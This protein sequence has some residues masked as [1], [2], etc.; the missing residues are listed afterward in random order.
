MLDGIGELVDI[1]TW[2]IARERPTWTAYSILMSDY[3]Q[4]V[5]PHQMGAVTL[6]RLQLCPKL[7][8]KIRPHV[9]SWQRR[10]LRC[11]TEG[12]L[13]FA[14][15]IPNDMSD[16][17]NA[18]FQAVHR[19][20]EDVDFARQRILQ[21][22][23]E[24][25]DEIR[26]IQKSRSRTRRS[27]PTR[28][29]HHLKG[30]KRNRRKAN[31]RR[32]P[33]VV[34]AGPLL[35]HD[36]RRLKALHNDTYLSRPVRD[37]IT[38]ILM[39]TLAT[40]AIG[41]L[42][43][44][45][46]TLLN[47]VKYS[48][49]DTLRK[50]VNLNSKNIEELY[51]DTEQIAQNLL[52]AYR[53][54]DQ[55]QDE[56]Q[57]ITFV[58]DAK[59]SLLQT[60][61]VFNHLENSL[62]DSTLQ[63]LVS[64]SF[65]HYGMIM[66]N[67]LTET[68]LASVAQALSQKFN[69]A[70]SS[71]IRDLTLDVVQHP[72]RKSFML[73]FQIPTREDFSK[74]KIYKVTAVP[75]LMQDPKEENGTMTIPVLESNFIGYAKEG[76]RI[77][78]LTPLEANNCLHTRQCMLATPLR[79]ADKPTTCQEMAFLGLDQHHCTW[80]TLAQEGSWFHTA[81]NVTFYSMKKPDTAEIVCPQHFGKEA[82]SYSKKTLT[83][84]GWM[85]VAWR[86]HIQMGD[87]QLITNSDADPIHSRLHLQA[88]KI[89]YPVYETYPH[90][91]EEERVFYNFTKLSNQQYT[92]D[93]ALL[94]NNVERRERAKYNHIDEFE[95]AGSA[96]FRTIAIVFGSLT[97]VVV[98]I[99]TI[100]LMILAY[101]RC[102]C[103]REC[104]RKTKAPQC[105]NHNTLESSMSTYPRSR[106]TARLTTEEPYGR[107]RHPRAHSQPREGHIRGEQAGRLPPPASQDQERRQEASHRQRPGYDMLDYAD[108]RSRERRGERDELIYATI[109]RTQA[110]HQAQEQRTRQ[111]TV[112]EPTLIS[113]HAPRQ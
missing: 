12:Q 64:L 13:I 109:S 52:R 110:R 54:I 104:Y 65:A 40:A 103:I 58:T 100:A 73:L 35:N 56:L 51:Q 67:L 25:T 94:A 57:H 63:L 82:R 18:H 11:S 112:A 17:S 108:L 59:L 106:G 107:T 111:K 47:T 66:Q 96:A 36:D 78:T 113:V 21:R 30:N 48:D 3:L 2:A 75:K 5:L 26:K 87:G 7:K 71:N 46:S 9:P 24:A 70:L 93:L 79:E 22:T 91:F 34:Y 20:R 102:K 101:R 32:L 49:V 27:A 83:G 33:H 74:L 92:A 10:D 1:V 60:Q 97:G 61:I 37:P 69:V 81:F 105:I 55:L 89:S 84:I 95:T 77:A 85:E 4:E 16:P 88:V 31:G 19:T 15:T 86:C 80:K 53:H 14:S 28:R 23:L 72:D 50:Q 68:E 99:V 6:K 44:G 43:H 41:T 38:L 8:A 76:K 90:A 45:A 29:G 98:A 39:A 42:F 62:L